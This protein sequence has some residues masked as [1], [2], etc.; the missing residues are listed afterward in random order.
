[1]INNI[2]KKYD[3]KLEQYPILNKKEDKIKAGI[4]SNWRSKY[5]YYLFDTTSGDEIKDICHNYLE[6]LEFT[7]DYYFHQNYHK[8][9]YYRYQ[10]SPTILDLSNY[11]QS[12]NYTI[13][14]QDE[15]KYNDDFRIKIE[16]NDLYPNIEINTTLQLLMILPPSSIHLIEPQYQKLM[17]DI[18]YGVLHY[19]PNNFDI[20]IY[21]KKWL[22]L[23]KPKLPDIDIILLNSK[24]DY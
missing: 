2:I 22:W 16:Y 11:L 1:M 13:I 3:N 4:D 10:Y 14:N 21:L 6:S 19:Y 7:L 23:C 5:Y 12:L 8:T 24:L 17:K 9:W 18:N 15:Q 20:S